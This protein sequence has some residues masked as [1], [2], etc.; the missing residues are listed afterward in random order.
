MGKQQINTD[1]KDRFR[2]GLENMRPRLEPP[3]TL[4]GQFGL[5]QQFLSLLCE[6]EFA[7]VALEQVETILRLK[8]VDCVAYR[9]NRTPQFARS[10]REAA[11][12]DHGQKHVELVDK[13][14]MHFDSSET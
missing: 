8:P 12:F 5:T 7:G 9:R 13:I 4:Q 10:T 1:T 2:A 14:L 6:P 3:G 11:R